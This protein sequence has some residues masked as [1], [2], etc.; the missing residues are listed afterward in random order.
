MPTAQSLVSAQ[1]GVIHHNIQNH[2]S[3]IG[4]SPADVTPI[5]EQIGSSNITMK[6]LGNKYSSEAI[7]SATPT[8]HVVGS[9]RSPSGS[10][11]IA[12][13]QRFQYELCEN[14]EWCRAIGLVP[15]PFCANCEFL[16]VLRTCEYAR[17]PDYAFQWQFDGTTHCCLTTPPLTNKRR[18]NRATREHGWNTNRAESLKELVCDSQPD[19]STACS[20]PPTSTTGLR[21]AVVG[22]PQ[23]ARKTTDGW[24]TGACDNSRIVLQRLLS[25]S[26]LPSKKYVRVANMPLLEADQEQEDHV[27]LRSGSLD[28]PVQ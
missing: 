28:S 9:N 15:R 26:T 19:L 23:Y 5:A 6:S 22:P 25:L 11:L 4:T 20:C 3:S 7:A 2:S 16:R 12:V 1:R 14:C 17:I 24:C 10:L 8:K 18:R 27:R 21:W 13:Y